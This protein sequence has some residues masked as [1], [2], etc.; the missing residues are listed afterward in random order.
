MD[1][2]ETIV[3]AKPAHLIGEEALGEAAEL[4]ETFHDYLNL[5]SVAFGVASAGG[6]R[7]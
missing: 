5:A 3:R 1:S 6:F 7:P 2:K 4:A